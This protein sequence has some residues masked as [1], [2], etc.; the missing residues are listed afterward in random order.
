MAQTSDNQNSAPFQ[1]KSGRPRPDVPVPGL[2][3]VVNGYVEAG[4][5]NSYEKTLTI[6]SLGLS[7]DTPTTVLLQ[8][9]QFTNQEFNFSDEFVVMVITTARDQMVVRIRRVD[10]AGG[11]GWGQDLR[12]DVLIVE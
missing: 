9:R 3:N 12:L 1:R 8:P 11:G 5:S 6:T 2:G 4:S 10:V 7:T